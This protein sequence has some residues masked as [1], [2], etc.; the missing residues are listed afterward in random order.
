[1]KAYTYQATFT[2]DGKNS[3]EVEKNLNDFLKKI[4]S[5]IPKNIL[6]EVDDSGEENFNYI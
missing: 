6:L 4:N 3:E 1:M 5:F 2:I